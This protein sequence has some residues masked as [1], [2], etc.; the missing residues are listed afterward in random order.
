MLFISEENN[1]FSSAVTLPPEGLQRCCNQNVC[2]PVH[3]LRMSKTACPN[4]TNFSLLVTCGSVL[5][6]REFK[7]IMLCCVPS[8][9]WRCWLGDRKGIRPVKNWVVGCWHG[10]LRWGAGLHIAHQMPLPL[11]VSCSSKSRLV[12]PFWYLLTRVVPDSS[13]RQI[14][15][16]Q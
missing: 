5:L 13:P 11:T 8:V 1:F 9:L 2:T 10:C 12:L 6:W 7:Y 15:E 3:S 16:E 4:F 14:A